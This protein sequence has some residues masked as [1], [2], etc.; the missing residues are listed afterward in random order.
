M[1]FCLLFIDCCSL[2]VVTR[3]LFVAAC[4][5]IDIRSQVLV[6]EILEIFGT[7]ADREAHKNPVKLWRRDLISTDVAF[8]KFF[9]RIKKIDI[10][11]GKEF[12]AKEL[13]EKQAYEWIKNQPNNTFQ[14]F[15]PGDWENN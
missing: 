14:G 9:K 15:I 5:L 8:Q 1:Y 6:V 12:D 2:T 10:P 13:L 3:L 11:D 4:L 7:K